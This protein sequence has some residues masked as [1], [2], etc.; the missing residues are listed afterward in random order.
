MTKEL[1]NIEVVET[2]QAVNRLLENKEKVKE[3][4]IKIRWAIKKNF[5]S[6]S[7]T[8]KS[9]E[10]LR[11]ELVGEL[12]EEFFN[13][14]KSNLKKVKMEDGSED[15]VRQVKDEFMEDYEKR[16]NELNLK[17]Q[18][19]LGE[20]NEYDIYTVDLDEFVESL[21]NDTKLTFEDIDV[22]SFMGNE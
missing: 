16:V 4:P 9:F 12:H 1:F 19:L 14:E 15:E 20:K 7:P 3:L 10:D 17:L 22:L 18:E 5:A 13:E 6:F 2:V 21:P 11:Q 8:V